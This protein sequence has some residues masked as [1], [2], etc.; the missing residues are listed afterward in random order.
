MQEPEGPWW[1]GAVQG[2]RTELSP[3]PQSTKVWVLLA[4]FDEGG[5][6]EQ[7]P[8]AATFDLLSRLMTTKPDRDWWARKGNIFP[9][10]EA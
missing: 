2:R 4:G 1:I 6:Q 7:A 10:L 5:G 3:L 8:S 9:I